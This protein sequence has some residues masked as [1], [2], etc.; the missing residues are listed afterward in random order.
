MGEVDLTR[1]TDPLPMPRDC[2]VTGVVVWL[3]DGTPVTAQLAPE[4][5]RKGDTYSVQNVTLT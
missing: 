2:T 5:L 1:P 3:E 4:K